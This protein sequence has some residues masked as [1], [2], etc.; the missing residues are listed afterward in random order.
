MSSPSEGT[1]F[2]FPLIGSFRELLCDSEYLPCRTVISFIDV[3]KYSHFQVGFDLEKVKRHKEHH[4]V[5]VASGQN[6][7]GKT[8]S[9]MGNLWSG[10]LW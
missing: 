1:H 4:L 2:I 3:F 8:L 9:L 7:L 10:A 6:L 5:N